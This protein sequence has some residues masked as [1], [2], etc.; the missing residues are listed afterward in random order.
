M[1]I[2]LSGEFGGGASIDAS[3]TYS[4][5]RDQALGFDGES[6]DGITAGNPNVAEWGRADEERAHQLEATMA[7]PVRRGIELAV[8]GRLMSGFPFTP[9]VV[10]DI[11]GDGERNDRAFI[12]DP[13]AT[14]DT[15]LAGG[16]RRLLASGPATARHCLPAQFGRTAERNGCTGPWVPGLDL[17]LSVTPRGLFRRRVTFALSA[18]NALIGIDELLHGKAGLHGWG[19]D[20]TSDRR[21]LFATGFDPVAQAFRYRVN[22]HFGAASGALNPFRIPFVL[23]I[24]ARIKLGGRT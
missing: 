22:Q 18:L 1:T 12:F 23:G 14:A 2:G 5:V 9:G 6:A 13:A 17:K 4:N 21:L 19:Q 8:I 11:N 24:Q 3:Y 7:I 10:Q 20:A 15:G 16:M